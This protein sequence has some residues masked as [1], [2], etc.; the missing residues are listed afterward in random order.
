MTDGDEPPAILAEAVSKRYGAFT[1]VERLDLHVRRGE[2]FCL[3]GPNGSGK[4]TFLRML[5]GYLAPSAGRLLVA[6]HDVVRD[7][8]AAKTEIG[9]VP[10]S[11]PL[12]SHMR[13]GE[14]LRFM[15]RLR[16]VPAAQVAAAVRR[17]AELLALTDVLRK[18]IRALSRGYRQRTALAQALVH[19]PEILILD[20]PTNG[21]DPRQIMET[22]ALIRSLSGRHTVLMSSHIL[23]EVEKTADRAALLLDGRLLGVRAL[24][25]TPDLE[26]WFL[27]VT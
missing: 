4:T 10:E 5:A 17:V 3:L 20:E 11:V 23:S 21:L 2:V 13:I 8:L 18:P 9:Y 16:R 27:S 19:D 26:A 24:A 7:G 6:G 1:A 12:Y 25:D 14:F 22:R 15:A